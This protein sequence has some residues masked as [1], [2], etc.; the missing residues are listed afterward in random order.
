MPRRWTPARLTAYLRCPV[1]RLERLHIYGVGGLGA[2]E[3]IVNMQSF[4]LGD[5]RG[6]EGACT[7]LFP[8]PGGSSGARK[9]SRKKFC[10][11]EVA[12]KMATSSIDCI[13]TGPRG[14]LEEAR[15]ALRKK[16][17]KLITVS[18][19][20][21]FS[22]SRWIDGSNCCILRV[23][24]GGVGRIHCAY[25]VGMTLREIGGHLA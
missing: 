15:N 4:C 23:D 9:G 17:S 20:K 13:F 21:K 18:K 12:T 24:R 1:R 8:L 10:K 3:S 6:L 14:H 5:E 7:E 2:T 22:N 25:A 19:K 16:A 11:S